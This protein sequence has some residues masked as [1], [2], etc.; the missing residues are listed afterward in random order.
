MTERLVSVLIPTLNGEAVLRRLLPA[1]AAQELPPG[2]RSELR[3][4]DSSSS[5][6]TRE[7]LARAGAVVRTIARGEFGH[8]RTRNQ[9][10]EQSGGELL[11]FLSQDAEPAG[12]GY[13]ASLIEAFDDE[14]TA[15]VS[16]RILP[17]PGDDALTTRTA[18]ELREASK[19]PRAVDLDQLGPLSELPVE[20]RAGLL[21]I[22][23]VASAV[24]ASVLRELPFPDVPFG[25]D[26]AWAARALAA[27]WRLRTVPAA[28][29]HHAHR[30][31]PLEAFERYRIDAAFRRA[32]F[33]VRVRP[34]LRS[35]ARGFLHELRADVRFVRGRAADPQLG[36]LLR[37]PLLRG[38]QVLGQYAGG[39]GW[40]AR[41]LRSVERIA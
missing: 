6:G 10:A 26:A 22:N 11:A 8:G 41:A 2:W 29:V 37:S 36:P 28:V 40:G 3:A 16:G 19:Q 34:N 17:H 18:L 39:L 21:C 25:E 1:L 38:A 5:D 23:N 14:R 33:G 27:G 35:A 13:L 20:R 7:L 31:G 32:A 15:G 12:R 4:V 9:L 30:Y 24:R